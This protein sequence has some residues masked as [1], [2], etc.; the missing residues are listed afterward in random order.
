M[1]RF[2]CWLLTSQLAHHTTPQLSMEVKAKAKAVGNGNKC[3]G[4]CIAWVKACAAGAQVDIYAFADSYRWYRY[5]SAL[6]ARLVVL[7]AG[8]WSVRGYWLHR[9][10]PHTQRCRLRAFKFSTSQLYW[11][12]VWRISYCVFP[13]LSC[14]FATFRFHFNGLCLLWS[15]FS[16]TADFSFTWP[17]AF[18]LCWRRF[19]AFAVAVCNNSYH[20]WPYLPNLRICAQPRW[21]S[22]V[23]Y[24]AFFCLCV[25][26][27]WDFCFGTCKS[28]VVASSFCHFHFLRGGF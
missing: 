25:C 9:N 8:V 14:F 27:C 21:I 4:A 2:A 20:D 19:S 16:H 10:S 6:Y 23:Q 13:P 5:V 3:D 18:A 26:V 22:V 15:V 11:V 28:I 7:R 17:C 12:C 1:R 24:I